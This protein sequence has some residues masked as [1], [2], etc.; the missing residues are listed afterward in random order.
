MK[1]YKLY[2][3]VCV[4]TY[5]DGSPNGI[6]TLEVYEIE[7]NE[8]KKF[9]QLQCSSDELGEPFYT[10]E[11]EIQNWLDDNGYEDKEFE[12]RLL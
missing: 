2:Y 6:R 4:E 7:N 11:E 5:S 12:F 8:P 10:N 3:T 9:V 1:K